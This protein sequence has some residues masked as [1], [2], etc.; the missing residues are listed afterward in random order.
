VGFGSGGPQLTTLPTS[1]GALVTDLR[2]L[3]LPWPLRAAYTPDLAA[4]TFAGL[5]AAAALAVTTALLARA[6]PLRQASLVGAV[7]TLAFLVPSLGLISI[8]ALPVAE[9]FL[10]LPSVGFVLLAGAAVERLPSRTTW[11]ACATAILVLAAGTVARERVWRDE[12]SLFRDTVG[13][14]P[15]YATGHAKLGSALLAAGRTEEAFD[16]LGRA[17]DAGLHDPEIAIVA[18]IAAARQGEPEVALRWFAF[19]QRFLPED[20]EVAAN[21]GGALLALGRTR[22]AVNVL[23]T[24][25]QRHPAR[26]ALWDRL[27]VAL[28]QAARPQE[29]VDAHARA[30]ALR[31]GDPDFLSNAGHALL[32]VGRPAQAGEYFRAALAVH[33]DDPQARFG[34]ILSL[35]RTGEADAARRELAKLR[36][37]D[38]QLE[39]LAR[40][41]V[42]P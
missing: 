14:S 4:V 9:R 12:L 11:A 29:A 13:K 32:A 19:A 10:Y 36:S 8:H 7:W 20:A 42:S 22:E 39:R 25:A 21:M 3:L 28:Q 37:A 35:A 38:P 26:A 41:E 23:H 27:G 31:P 2:L 15:R 33:P 24:A 40:R 6:A 17:W 16:V 34:W 18:G 30:L 1:L 5:L